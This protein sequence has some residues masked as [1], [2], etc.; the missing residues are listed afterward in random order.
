M[1]EIG[2]FGRTKNDILDNIFLLSLPIMLCSIKSLATHC[3]YLIHYS[4]CAKEL[5]TIYANLLMDLLSLLLVLVLCAKILSYVCYTLMSI[6]ISIF[7][8]LFTFYFMSVYVSLYYHCVLTVIIIKKLLTYLLYI[9]N[10]TNNYR[11][12]DSTNLHRDCC[13]H[14][15]N[16]WVQIMIRIATKI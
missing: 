1:D 4:P 2:D 3:M 16:K 8:C 5:F 6:D 14:L 7:T 13:C 15:A 11:G 9:D 12:L 10:N